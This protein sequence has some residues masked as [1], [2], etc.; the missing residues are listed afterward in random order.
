MTI[1]RTQVAGKIFLEE[2]PGSADSGARDAAGFGAAAKF[3]RVDM[4][5]RSCLLE[6]KS[7]HAPLRP[8]SCGPGDRLVSI[9]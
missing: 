8:A 7:V 1:K 3:F 2:Y 9:T 6:T 5:V 4:Q